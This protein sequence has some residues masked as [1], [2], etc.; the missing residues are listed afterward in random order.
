MVVR[1]DFSTCFRND[2]HA[3]FI[4]WDI[5]SALTSFINREIVMHLAVS[6]LGLMWESVSR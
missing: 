1:E 4:D 5:Q 6:Y 3:L 2:F